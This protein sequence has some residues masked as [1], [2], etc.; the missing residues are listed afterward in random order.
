MLLCDRWTRDE[1][2]ESVGPAGARE[3][4]VQLDRL[5][6]EHA[7]VHAPQPGFMSRAASTP[8]S[9]A[10]GVSGAILQRAS[11]WMNVDVFP[12]MFQ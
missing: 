4:T 2:L 10:S 7:L 1:L 9:W 11:S 6:Q 8:L 5:D 3:V 12:R